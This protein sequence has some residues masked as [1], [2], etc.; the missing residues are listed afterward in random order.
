[1]G[2]DEKKMR[3]GWVVLKGGKRVEAA[4]T[5]EPGASGLELQNASRTPFGRLSLPVFVMNFLCQQS[6]YPTQ[7]MHDPTFS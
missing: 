3:K 4:E 7:Y 5:L 2:K 1:M 6:M